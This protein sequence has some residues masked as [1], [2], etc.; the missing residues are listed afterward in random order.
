MLAAPDDEDAVYL[1]L[2]RALENGE[3]SA[4]AAALERLLRFR[5]DH[6]RAQEDLALLYEKMGVGEASAPAADN[7]TKISGHFAIGGGFDTNPEATPNDNRIG[8]FIPVLDRVEQIDLDLDRE[9]SPIVQVSAGIE[10]ETAPRGGLPAFV[11]ELDGAATHYTEA[12]DQ[13]EA[14]VSLRAG[15]KFDAG[16]FTVRPFAEVAHQWFDDDSYLTAF[17]GGVALRRAMGR[18]VLRAEAGLGW[19]EY[20]D[21]PSSPDRDDLTGMTGF[22]SVSL[23][24]TLGEGL[25]GRVGVFAD[26]RDARADFQRRL[27]V[28]GFGAL[29]KEI[30]PGAGLPDLTLAVGGRAAVIF[31]DGADPTFDPDRTRRDGSFAL[32]GRVSAALSEENSVD[33]TASYRSRLSRYDIYESD[34]VR[35]VARF[36]R[37]F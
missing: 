16:G 29:Y 26:G 31:Y 19:S 5:P 30:S 11:F 14:D 35:V 10:I 7:G 6:R 3:L 18:T 4:A 37:R 32:F 24:R 2:K 12:S 36:V 22:A 28:G 17:R 23:F 9:T 33:F 20:H 27:Q 21:T 15:P 1:F 25:Y 8:L 34:G 13:D